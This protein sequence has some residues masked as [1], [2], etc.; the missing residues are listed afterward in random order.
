MKLFFKKLRN[1]DRGQAILLIALAMVGLVAF[2]GLMTDGGILLIEYGKLKR[3]IDAAAIASAQQFRRGFTGADLAAAAQNFLILNE[4]EASQIKIYRCK[5]EEI[6]DGTIHDADLCTTPRRKLVRVEATRT[7]NF[8]FL[9]IVGIE[10]TD[11][12]A[13][14]VGEAASIDLVLIIDTSTSMSYETDGDPNKPDSP[15]D[16]P[17]VCNYSSTDPCEPLQSVKNVALEFLNTMYFPYDRVAVVAFTSQP[18]NFVRDRTTVLALTDDQSVVEDAISNLKVF[19][20]PVC[21]NLKVS[22][23]TPDSGPCRQYD[24]I[25][26]SFVGYACPRFADTGYVDLSSCNSSNI[27][28]ALKLAWTEF[29]AGTVRADAVWITIMLAGGPANATDGDGSPIPD[30]GKLPDP[31]KYP[32]GYCPVIPPDD[33][34]CRDGDPNLRHDF[35]DPAYDADDYARD[36]ADSVADPVNGGGITIYTIGL[37]NLIRNTTIGAP[38]GGE[39]L[40]EYIAYTAGGSEASHGLYFYA[41]NSSQLASIFDDIAEDIFTKIA[42]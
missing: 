3:G 32:F 25:D 39:K 16:D 24:E 31:G 17:S 21:G 12:S 36:W 6:E 41:P 28:G 5:D 23:A 20:P 40:L 15:L 29:T 30:A 13:S 11:I 8:G 2:V 18:P 35:G 34:P 14:S 42:K 38:D 33:P 26:G 10:S 4:A 22:P 19:E 1:A 37:G 27:G 7:V 9:R